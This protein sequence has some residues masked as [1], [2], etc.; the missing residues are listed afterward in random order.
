MCFFLSHSVYVCR[1]R[2][3]ERI[4]SPQVT[5]AAPD[6]KRF[7][8]AHAR[9]LF[10]AR[11]RQRQQQQQHTH[12]VAYIGLSLRRPKHGTISHQSEADLGYVHIDTSTSP[13]LCLRVVCHLYKHITQRVSVDNL[14][15]NR[16]EWMLCEWTVTIFYYIVNNFANR[17]PGL[18]LLSMWTHAYSDSFV[19]WYTLAS[20]YLSRNK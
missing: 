3:S 20:N 1:H 12:D 9:W 6:R 4:S 7:V 16:L 18:A 10:P 13:G 15:W 14:Q 19:S 11:S 2:C 8:N 17:A 5:A